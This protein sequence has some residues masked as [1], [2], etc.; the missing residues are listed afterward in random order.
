MSL[1]VKSCSINLIQNMPVQK[2]YFHAKPETRSTNPV[3]LWYIWYNQCPV[4]GVDLS[5][6]FCT[7]NKETTNVVLALLGHPVDWRPAIS[8]AI[9]HYD[10]IY[11]SIYYALAT[12]WLNSNT[13][14]FSTWSGGKNKVKKSSKQCPVLS[15]W[16]ILIS[17]IL[18]YI[19]FHLQVE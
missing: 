3:K 1:H 11:K 16:R 2:M 18:I 14:F 10:L 15:S 17:D 7:R 12:V 6:V 4:P 8:R 19:S 5:H 9:R 13:Y